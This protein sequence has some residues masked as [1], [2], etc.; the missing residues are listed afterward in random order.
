MRKLVARVPGAVLAD[1]FVRDPVAAAIYLRMQA[2]GIRR[3]LAAKQGATILFYPDRPHGLF[4]IWKVAKVLGL[5]PV[6]DLHDGADVRV[7]WDC[8]TVVDPATRDR[9]S[10]VGSRAL[11]L[12]AADISKARVHDVF[13]ATFGYSH[14]IDPTVH[15]ETCVEKSD[16]NARHDGQVVRCPIPARKHGRVYERE[17]DNTVDSTTVQ[18]IRVPVIGGTIPFAYKKY[19][20]KSDR[21]SNA[22]RLVEIEPADAL[23]SADER[24]RLIEF[25]RG[26]GCD[27]C[28]MD[29]LR[30]NGDGR[31]YVVDVNTTSFGPPSGLPLKPSLEAIQLWAEAFEREFL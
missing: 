29:V 1:R 5:R 2:L 6:T 18:D 19:R 13:A 7:L 30:D 31:I 17:I 16:A 9:M 28:E 14:A 21:F 22:N 3:R 23:L 8:G 12:D 10:H 15:E 26:M 4:M 25:C 27:V 20:P 24:R 11:N